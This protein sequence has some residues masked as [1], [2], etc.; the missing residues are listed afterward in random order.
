MDEQFL[1]AFEA[2]IESASERLLEIPEAETEKPLDNGWCAKQILGHLIDS[3]TNN[4]ARFVCAQFQAHLV[5]PDYAQDEWV[6]VQRYEQE[7]WAALV[8]LWTEFNLHLLHIIENISN[9]HLVKTCTLQLLD[10]SALPDTPRTSA[11]ESFTLD[12]LIRDYFEHMQAHLKYIFDK[13]NR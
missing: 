13:L 3:A 1:R 5:F 11:T 7:A 2:A 9:E 10:E 12:Y 8:D 4:H 6:R